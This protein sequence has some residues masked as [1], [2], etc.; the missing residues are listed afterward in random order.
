MN[1]LAFVL[2]VIGLL[3]VFD[4][5]VFYAIKP[6]TSSASTTTRRVVFGL[7]WLVSVFSV[8]M[9][10]F[11]VLGGMERIS[12]IARNF[13]FTAILGN[14]LFKVLMFIFLFIEDIYRVLRLGVE[15]VAQPTPA[16]ELATPVDLV[17]RSEFLSKTALFVA[18]APAIT[19]SLG[20]ISGA[21]DY[22]VRR[23]KLVLPHLP[24][25]FDGIKIGQLSDIHSGS[26]YNKKAVQGGVEMM[27]AEKP[28]LL[29]FTGDLVNNTADEAVDYI[30]IFSKLK[31]SM[32]IYSTLGNHD[33]GDYVQWA[34]VEAKRRNLE[35]LK[36]AHKTMGW[37]LLMNEHVLFGKEGEQL[38]VLGIENFGAKGHFPKYGKLENAYRGTEDARV[39]LLLSHDPSHWDYQ[40][41]KEYQDI[42]VMFAG[43]THGMQFGVDTKWLKWSPVQ[44]MY[45]QWGGLYK[46]AQQYLYVN[47]GF[48]FLGY[49]GRVGILPELTIVTLS[50]N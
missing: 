10:L 37:K 20:V 13:I 41:R 1:R 38:A 2:L 12:S 31:A 4:T 33:Y 49:P 22:R 32:G 30:P 21:Y 9:L 18:S 19:L 47:R 27:N 23:T 40:V 35:N 24:K 44:Y 42:D 16:S 45:K 48:G 17:S 5:Y 8:G 3:I 39:K 25:E 11:F 15:K 29:F 50:R 14:I 28:D 36:L 43:H 6:L 7:Y 26:F 34:S 46:E